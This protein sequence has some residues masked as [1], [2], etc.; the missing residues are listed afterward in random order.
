MESASEATRLEAKTDSFLT[1]R[2][3]RLTKLQPGHRVLDAG[4]GTG[5]VARVM[6]DRVGPHGAVVA[7][8]GSLDRSNEGR[9]IAKGAGDKA[10]S[11][12]SGDLRTIPVRDGSFDYVWCRFVFE[13]LD[14]PAVVFDELLRVVRPGGKL[15]IGD[16]DGNGLF[17]HPLP[18]ELSD[19]L[20]Q[21][22][23]GLRGR[24][25][26][27]AGRKLY[28]LFWERRLSQIRTHVFPYNLYAGA[29]GPAALSNWRQK[30]DTLLPIGSRVL[31]V[32]GYQEFTRRFLDFLAQEG[33]LSYSVLFLVEGIR[34]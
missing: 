7:L 33:T 27:T 28:R 3:L 23:S 6:A 34:T 2:L 19:G 16:L 1:R 30:L 13:Y 12:V 21:L 24:F 14:D 4:A 31:G 20:A 9:R 26:P 25:D 10:I 32:S 5:A 8:D 18:A 11:F 15:V 17:H 29:A 22:E